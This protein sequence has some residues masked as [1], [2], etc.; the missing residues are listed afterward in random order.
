MEEFANGTIDLDT[1]PEDGDFPRWMTEVYPGIE[2]E[3]VNDVH[4]AMFW[5]EYRKVIDKLNTPDAVKRANAV[6][7]SNATVHAVVLAPA[8]ERASILALWELKKKNAYAFVDPEAEYESIK[9]WLAA[10]LTTVD[11]N[12]GAYSEIRFMLEQLLPW[13]EKVGE[14]PEEILTIPMRYTKM[15]RVISTLRQQFEEFHSDI[16]YIDQLKREKIKEIKESSNEE[17]KEIKKEIKKI[18]KEY[19]E[20]EEEAIEKFTSVV[21]ATLQLIAD[22]SSS[23]DAEKEV[24]KLR[25]GYT[26]TPPKINGEEFLLDE[27]RSII[28]VKCPNRYYAHEIRSKLKSV[29]E[30]WGS[31]SEY[32]LLQT[33]SKG[34]R[35]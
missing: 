31:G 7:L 28:V 23:R 14:I 34:F 15:R 4:R 35:E 12:H 18:E 17:V 6:A 21:T 27:N 30:E 9:E 25:A 3:I 26:G 33:I 13:F 11:T 10:K 20:Q 5:K 22:D 29:I 1:I 2:K 32:D 19:T 16:D 24:R 8:M